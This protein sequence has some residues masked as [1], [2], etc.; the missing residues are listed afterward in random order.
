MLVHGDI[1]CGR[2]TLIGS[3]GKQ[4]KTLIMRPPT[5]HVDAILDSGCK[6]T[7][8]RN[9]EEIFEVLDYMRQEGDK[10]DWFWM[11][12]ISLLQ[13]IG[14]DDVYEGVLDSKGGAGSQARKYRE[15]FGPDR[16]EYRV[17]MWRLEQWVRHAVGLGSFNLGIMAHSFWYEPDGADAPYLAPWIQGKAMPQ[18]ICGMMNM[19]GYMEVAKRTI[20]GQEREVRQ[21][22]WNKTDTYY[23]KNQFKNRDGTSVF[24]SGITINPTMPNLVE[25][26][27][28]GRV[29][30]NGRRPTRIRRQRR[31]Q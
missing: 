24:P 27:E 3:G 9:W 8:V 16:G 20:R 31:E 14:L 17:N 29:S 30:A 7:I 23:A 13:D 22:H 21:I 19:V 10:W 15:R 4:F 18:K 6:E 11:D 12:S 1:G 2:T 25:T 28:K 26:I 5:D